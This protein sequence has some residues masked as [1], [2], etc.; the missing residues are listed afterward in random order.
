MGSKNQ[1]D[2]NYT[3]PGQKRGEYYRG[4]VNDTTYDSSDVS[5]VTSRPEP[6]SHGVPLT[7]MAAGATML[8]LVLASGPFSYPYGFVNTSP[9]L[10]IVLMGVISVFSY[11]TATFM[12]EA[13][14]ISCAM[15]FN[16]D[17]DERTIYP[18]LPGEDPSIKRKRDEADSDVKESPY[19][20][21]EKVEISKM[22]DDHLH[23]AAKYVLFFIIACYMY[24]A[25]IF[26][27][28]AGAKSLSEGISFTF[29]GEKDKYDEQFKFYY[30][31]IAVFAV[32]SLMFSLGNIENSRVLQVV[33]MYL[34]FLTTFLMIVGSLISI[35]RHGITFKMSDNVPDISHVPNLVSNTVF[36]FVVHHSVA[37]IVKPVRPQKAVYPLIFYS[38]TVGGAI[39]VVEA[40]LAALAFSHIDNKDCNKFPCEIQGL[41]NE[42]FE[43][44]PVIGQ[45]TNFYPT[46]N[47]AAIPILTITLRN[48]LFVLLNIPQASETRLTK[49][50]WSFGLSV[51]VVIVACVFQDPQLI[52]TY[53]G[54]LGGT[55]ILFIIPCVMIIFARKNNL[56]HLYQTDNFNKSAFQNFIWPILGLLMATI[57]LGTTFYG[58][59]K[60]ESGE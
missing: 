30:I 24:G 44:I 35:F 33:S 27:Y 40:M 4:V 7:P 13:L 10:G 31:C 47:V 58:I 36:I 6:K 21:R 34:R 52:M 45:I 57:S 20:I 59:I 11:M 15:R 25:M 39:L 23:V 54:G 2:I 46:L 17:E 55:C 18:S 56:Q 8:N 22:C 1:D 37:G 29:T 3:P 26:K 16:P 28:V 41:Y 50:L 49:A 48:N 60:G 38:F 42:N 12:V 19:Y 9:F 5:P 43:A 53:T 14:S 51:P 32:V